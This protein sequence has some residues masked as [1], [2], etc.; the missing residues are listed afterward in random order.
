MLV[1]DEPL[2]RE[3][4]ARMLADQLDYELVG[5][6]A[7]G[8]QAL[9]L[10]EAERPELVLL[11]IAMPGMSGLEL[12]TH[13][14]TLASPPAIIFCTAHDEHALK[15]FEAHA[16]DYL[17][18][19]IKA[20][21]LSEALERARRY[22]DSDLSAT[23]QENDEGR[24]HICARVRGNLEL[25]PIE[26]V[27]FFHAEHKYVTVCHEDGEVLIEEALTSLENDLG[28]RFLRIHRNALV[29][30]QRIAALVRRSDGQFCVRMAG[31]DT[32]LDVS[33][34]NLPR[35]RRLLKDMEGHA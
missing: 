18:K 2:A 10:I 23:R 3:R 8:E 11:D 32:L 12:A 6:A 29:D 27:I 25:I 19:P 33:R 7:N 5:Q 30:S 4:L 34:R 13:L 24:Q 16:I 31:C 15:A 9:A 35:V 20:E 1:D 17:L 21:R 26:Q 28:E 22:C 14:N